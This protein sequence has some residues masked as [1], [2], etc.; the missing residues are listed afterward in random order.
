[1]GDRL[2]VPGGEGEGD[3]WLLTFV[4]DHAAG[5]SD[6]AILNA[7]DVTAGPVAEIRLPRRVPDGFHGV[8]IPG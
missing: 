5:T 8:W 4:Y 3:G 2:F 7:L 1:M 6:L